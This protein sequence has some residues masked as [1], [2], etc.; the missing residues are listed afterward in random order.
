MG[1][2]DD[3]LIKGSTVCP[4]LV[5]GTVKVVTKLAD[6]S[7]VNSG[8]IMVVR[9]SSPAYATGVMNSAG[10]ITERGG[11]LAHICIVSMEMGIPSIANA[12]MATELLED[13]M[14]VTLDATEGTVYGRSNGEY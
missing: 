12:E 10:L 3:V 14:L 11:K 9:N 4:G 2:R 7:K 8:D 5:S 6:I 13:N 1:R